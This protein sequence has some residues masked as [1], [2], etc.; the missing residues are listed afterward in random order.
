MCPTFPEDLSLTHREIMVQRTDRELLYR[1][2]SATFSHFVLACL[3]YL[4][5][6]YRYDHP[7]VIHAL[8]AATFVLGATRRLTAV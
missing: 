4:S 3:V 5:T 6:S 1:S 7:R 8:L 2:R